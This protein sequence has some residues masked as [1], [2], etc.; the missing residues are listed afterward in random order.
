MAIF[1]ISDLHL[2]KS[3][4]KPMDIFGGRW[5]NYMERLEK[6][7]RQ[8]VSAEDTVLVPGD[9]SW[10]TYLDEA[11]EDFRLIDSLP[12]KKI[13]SKGNHDY[14]WTTHSKLE[15][16]I[17][18]NSFNTISFMHN[19]SF[20]IEGFAVCGTRGWTLPGD[21]DF[22]SEDRKIY[23]R[24]LKRLELSLKSIGSHHPKGVIAALHFPVMNSKGVFSEFLDIMLKYEVTHCIYGHLH[25]EAHR[26]VQEG[27]IKGIE[28]R[29]V[30]AD[31][32][33]FKPTRLT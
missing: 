32:L 8:T 29:L 24:E 5:A 10:A 22:S 33:G 6:E 15:K 18:G 13:I 14:W 11:Y 4:D 26:H 19:N 3:V 7:W 30:A 21:D 25:G 17:F 23:E 16:F 12:G 27:N 20:E 31:Y 2:A 9:I 1:A 28:F